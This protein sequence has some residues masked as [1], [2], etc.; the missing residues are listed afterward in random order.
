MTISPKNEKTFICVRDISSRKHKIVFATQCRSSS[1][2]FRLCVTGVVRHSVAACVSHVSQES[3]DTVAHN[4]VRHSFR[5][6]LCD[7][8]S[9][10]RKTCF[11]EMRHSVAVFRSCDTISKRRKIALWQTKSHFRTGRSEC[12]LEV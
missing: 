8:V 2:C 5:I 10:S 3:C 11:S 6:V 4:T 7:T 9:Q 12:K 1:T